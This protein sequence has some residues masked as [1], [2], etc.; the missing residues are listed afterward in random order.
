VVAVRRGGASTRPS[1][2]NCANAARTSVRLIANRFR[3][4]P[5]AISLPGG[6]ACSMIALAQRLTGQIGAGGFLA[7]QK[8]RCGVGAIKAPTIPHTIIQH[9]VHKMRE[10][11]SI[12]WNFGQHIAQS[13]RFE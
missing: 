8:S 6:S 4:H 10:F 9:L 3:V 13:L 11:C 1:D 12:R 7:H 5:P 2:C